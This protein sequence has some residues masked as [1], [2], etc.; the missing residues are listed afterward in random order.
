MQ[1]RTK[2]IV[3]IIFFSAIAFFLLIGLYAHLF[4][5]YQKE[6]IASIQDAIIKIIPECP[7]D[8]RNIVFVCI[9]GLRY[10]EAFAAE[11]E[12]IP[13][14]W[15][16]LRPEGTIFTN[17]WIESASLTTTVHSTWLAGNEQYLSNRG[18]IHPTFPTFIE[19]YRDTRRTWFEREFEEKLPKPSGFFPLSEDTEAK[20]LEI[21]GSAMDFPVER[22]YCV[23]GKDR[24]LDAV[25]ISSHPA[26]GE[27]FDSIHYHSMPDSEV[28]NIF[29]AR[30]MAHKPKM[31]FLNFADV[32]EEGHTADWR[33]YTDAIRHADELVWEMWNYLQ[34]VPA[35]RDKTNLFIMA[36]H[37][38][39]DDA[40]GGF[41]HHGCRCDGCLHVPALMMGPDFKKGA[42]VDEYMS[43]YDVQITIG[44]TLGIETPFAK[45]RVLEEALVD[46]GSLPTPME[47][48]RTKALKEE[49]KILQ[50]DSVGDWL[51][52][53]DANIGIDD[54]ADVD[55]FTLM[56]YLMGRVECVRKRGEDA[57]AVKRMI[58]A[59]KDSPGVALP[60][61]WLAEYSGDEANARIAYDAAGEMYENVK[62]GSTDWLSLREV[63]VYGPG[64]CQAGAFFDEK[65]WMKKGGEILLRRMEALE[66]VVA[67]KGTINDF[68]SRFD[69]FDPES[70]MYVRNITPREK[71]LFFAA[72]GLALEDNEDNFDDEDFYLL[73][74]NL[75]LQMAF[76]APDCN[77]M[78][79]YA[80]ENGAEYSAADIAT[81]Y[82]YD[83][84]IA[85]LTPWEKDEFIALGYGP[86]INQTA[87][88]D[89]PAEHY[90]YML[91]LGN[92]FLNS[93]TNYNKIRITI[94]W[95]E[96]FADA[97]DDKSEAITAL[98]A[99]LL[100]GARWDAV[101]DEKYTF[102]LFPPEWM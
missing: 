61:L 4:E 74:R 36:D 75:R 26:Y 15:N 95:D 41:A 12:F 58:K 11:D 28:Y 76:A 27:E 101:P 22:T 30:L 1:R 90:F 89:F 18:Y 68:I 25:N 71:A 10:D 33:K 97:G 63:A 77:E 19:L 96:I 87:I 57:G 47:T 24:I 45:G 79:L 81:N 48:E 14:I 92:A 82:I 52:W 73:K 37:G 94:D 39:H 98:G 31:I 64:L 55:D 67:T 29:E 88:E 13:H 54:L 17:S 2:I 46:P 38:R 56:T 6:Y 40:H 70:G 69:Y 62:R 5:Q 59:K 84:V 72:F 78:C 20:V 49:M 53:A 7:Y 8:K 42:V 51:M 83:A 43:E 50:S 102:N 34:S 3:L 65:A 44:A 21:V 99:A 32:D 23:V 16:D 91:N 93:G 9:D 100:A 60:A 86:E 66:G 35:Y 80:G 85:P